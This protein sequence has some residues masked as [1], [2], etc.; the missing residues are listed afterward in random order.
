MDHHD[1][2]DH[3]R[4]SDNHRHAYERIA[5][6]HHCLLDEYLRWNAYGGGWGVAAANDAF[7]YG[8]CIYGEFHTH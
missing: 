1:R 3:R 4:K 6:G 8:P 2:H 7:C 5:Y